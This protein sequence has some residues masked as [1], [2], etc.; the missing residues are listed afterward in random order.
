MQKEENPKNFPTYEFVHTAEEQVDHVQLSI[1]FQPQGQGT[2]VKRNIRW[3]EIDDFADYIKHNTDWL[4][5]WKICHCI[6]HDEGLSHRGGDNFIR[7]GIFER[8]V[9]KCIRRATYVNKH[10]DIDVIEDPVEL[11]IGKDLYRP[12]KKIIELTV[13][14]DRPSGNKKNK[15]QEE[16]AFARWIESDRYRFIII[17]DFSLHLKMLSKTI[18]SMV[19]PVLL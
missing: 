12:R 15:E 13:K 14:N 11:K 2:I 7:S 19:I 1:P 4:K 18:Q 3:N 17:I 9:T 10:Y 6:I 5:L 16:E 8:A